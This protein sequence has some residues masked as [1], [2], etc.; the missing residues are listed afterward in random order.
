M[1]RYTSLHFTLRPFLLYFGVSQY[2]SNHI[3][4]RRYPCTHPILTLQRKAFSSYYG[5]FQCLINHIYPK[6]YPC[7]RPTLTLQRKAF[8]SY[9]G[10]CQYKEII[11]TP[12]DIR[13]PA[14]YVYS[15]FYDGSGICLSIATTVKG[16]D[17][18]AV[19]GS[20]VT[21]QPLGIIPH[22]RREE[23]CEIADVE[24]IV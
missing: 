19:S 23:L 17:S 21:Q 20:A 15:N 16:I 2:L 12:G 14:E 5:F 3:Y 24:F 18:P 13:V 8:S 11:F 4:P 9:Y 10:V 7:T 1:C 6:R 22:S